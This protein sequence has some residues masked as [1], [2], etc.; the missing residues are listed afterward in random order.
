M[1]GSTIRGK[2]DLVTR[3]HRQWE[4]ADIREMRRCG[5]TMMQTE[6]RNVEVE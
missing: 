5:K 4:K 6:I 1:L 2:K 3:R